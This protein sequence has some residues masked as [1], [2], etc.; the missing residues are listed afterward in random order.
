MAEV[1]LLLAV[2]RE[3]TF[4]AA[5][6]LSK[7]GTDPNAPKT[8]QKEHQSAGAADARIR[9]IWDARSIAIGSTNKPFEVK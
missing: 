8:A 6:A 9:E 5:A 7:Y 2:Y 4:K 1:K 3:A